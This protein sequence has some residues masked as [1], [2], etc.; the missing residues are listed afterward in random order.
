MSSS[1]RPQIAQVALRTRRPSLEP[2]AARRRRRAGS[3][4]PRRAAPQP[5][6]PAAR[7]PFCRTGEGGPGRAPCVPAAARAGPG[8]AGRPGSSSPNPGSAVWRRPEPSL[9]LTHLP[10]NKMVGTAGAAAGT[11][12]GP[13]LAALPDRPPTA[14]STSPSSI[15][16]SVLLYPLP[17]PHLS[18]PPISLST[19]ISPSAPA[20]F[21]IFVSFSPFPLL[22]PISPPHFSGTFSAGVFPS[23]PRM[24]P[25]IPAD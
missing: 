3:R 4:A 22:P 16:L 11:R 7:T 14:A 15:S 19:S 18:P 9:G 13:C 21:P 8:P 10:G 5:P 12:A 24:G 20:S 23:P 2:R 17:S 1:A 6:A 25:E